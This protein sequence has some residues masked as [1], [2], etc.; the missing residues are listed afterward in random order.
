[1]TDA[2]RNPFVVRAYASGDYKEDPN[3]PVLLSPQFAQWGEDL[4]VVALVRAYCERWG[5]TEDGLTYCEIGAYHPIVTSSTYLLNQRLGMR[6]VLVEANEKLLAGLR[7]E[8]PRDI[9]VHA[10]ITDS[11]IDKVQFTVS[12]S[13]GLSSLDEKIVRAWPMAG[14]AEHV[15]VPAM[16]INELFKRHFDASPPIYLSIDV[17]GMDFRLLQSMNWQAYRPYIVQAEPFDIYFQNNTQKITSFMRTVDYRL[18]AKTDTNL[19]FVDTREHHS[20]RTPVG[21]TLR[22]LGRWWDTWRT[23]RS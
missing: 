22:M 12:T 18:I 10:A 19:I 7:A 5:I 21:T 3:F 13:A 14:V 16:H 23:P 15:E 1:M 20:P 6:G 17:E 4:I 2:I 9:V 8:R 11:E